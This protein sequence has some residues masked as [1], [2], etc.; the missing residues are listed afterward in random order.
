MQ[1]SH[2][3]DIA[4]LLKNKKRCAFQLHFAQIEHKNIE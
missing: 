1:K 4:S 3:F 2:L